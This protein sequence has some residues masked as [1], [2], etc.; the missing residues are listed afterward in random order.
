MRELIYLGSSFDDL[1]DFPSDVREEV[2]FALEIA[3]DGGK[4]PSA[5]PLTGFRG[6]SVLE[7]VEA[8]D[9]DAY[10]A[11]YTVRFRHAVYVL[12]AFKKKSKSGKA[13]PR[14][15]IAMIERRLKLAEADAAKRMK[16]D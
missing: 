12:H 9:G 10:R 5:K 1:M 8:F 7:V 3:L 14:N 4:A 13:T 15:D 6:S 16:K 11:V 2:L